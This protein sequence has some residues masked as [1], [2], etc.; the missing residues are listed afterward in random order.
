ML[1]GDQTVM[2][3]LE[4]YQHFCSLPFLGKVCSREG[5]AAAS[6]L[7][8]FYSKRGPPL[9]NETFLFLFAAAA[10]V[11]MQQLRQS[12]RIPGKKFPLSRRETESERFKEKS[13]YAARNELRY[14]Q[15][16]AKP[17]ELWH[18]AGVRRE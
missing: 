8:S 18:H 14:T 5:G 13:G 17:L 4:G 16:G 2:H 15:T 1:D 10:A 7:L 11:T 9:R 12:F 6:S 3:Y